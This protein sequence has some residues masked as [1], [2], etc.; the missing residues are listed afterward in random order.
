LGR[1][2]G[3][4]AR[5]GRHARRLLPDLEGL[6]WPKSIEIQQREWI[7]RS[8]VKESCVPMDAHASS[9][10]WARLARFLAFASGAVVLLGFAALAA[11]SIP[12]E[13]LG[14]M[15]AAFLLWLVSRP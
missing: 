12:L 4:S 14:L 6:D 13:S 8:V 1:C 10:H 5:G 11:L 3:P 15:H 2:R 9:P 7:G